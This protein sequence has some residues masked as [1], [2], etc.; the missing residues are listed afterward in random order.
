MITK[1]MP[2]EFSAEETAALIDLLVGII[3]R[4]PFPQSAHVQRLRGILEKIRPRPTMPKKTISTITARRTLQPTDQHD[5]PDDRGGNA[6]LD[7]AVP[8]EPL[9][10]HGP[11]YVPS[12][13]L[14]V[15]NEKGRT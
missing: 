4:R 7:S 13:L 8:I 14:L 9:E 15:R 6:D 10:D 5:N 12:G 1:R 3:E 11:V 2:V